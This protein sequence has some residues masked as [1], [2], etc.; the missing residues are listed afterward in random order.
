MPRFD[1]FYPN[2]RKRI[3]SLDSLTD[4]ETLP[5]NLSPE[6]ELIAR[7]S[8]R[9]GAAESHLGTLETQTHELRDQL[10]VSHSKVDEA[11]ESRDYYRREA[12][13]YEKYAER[14]DGQ[15]KE[16][17]AHVEKLDK[18]YKAKAKKVSKK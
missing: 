5:T 13:R 8:Y 18:K 16:A 12:E 10:N 4:D 9:L 11:N 1:E 6:V 15:L 3:H 2:V 17:Y 7:A 14:V